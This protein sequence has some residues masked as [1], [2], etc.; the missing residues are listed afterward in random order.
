M[1]GRAI[2]GSHLVVEAELT[3]QLDAAVE[4]FP[5]LRVPPQELD[6]TDV[7]QRLYSRS[8]IATLLR[9][10][11]RAGARG[12]R[13]VEVVGR[14]AQVRE[15]SVGPGQFAA[16]LAALQRSDRLTDR[17]LRL[18]SAAQNPQR[19]RR[20]TQR[21]ALAET[22]PRRT[23]ALDGAATKVDGIGHPADDAVFVGRA[24]EKLRSLLNRQV[25]RIAESKRVLGRGFAMRADRGR[26]LGGRGSEPLHRLRVLRRVRVVREKREGWGAA[27]RVRE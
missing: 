4:L 7:G 13:S 8:F 20:G 24:V 3:R 10:R 22:V 14:D 12:D 27:R 5:A 1:R 26:P 19:P 2:R 21:M 17:R 15:H 6:R 11:K 23:V 9:E 25:L 16:G 18:V